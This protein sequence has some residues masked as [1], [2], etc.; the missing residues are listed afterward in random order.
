MTDRQQWKKISFLMSKRGSVIRNENMIV[1]RDSN[2]YKWNSET[3][4]NSKEWK[5]NPIGKKELFL[6]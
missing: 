4:L 5:K 6:G 3:I 2:N 1:S